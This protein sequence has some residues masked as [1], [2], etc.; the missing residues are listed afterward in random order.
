[1][2]AL[3][4]NLNEIISCKQNRLNEI[5]QQISTIEK[6]I[7]EI[8]SVS[9]DESIEVILQNALTVATTRQE[10]DTQ[11]EVL[12]KVESIA[13]QELEALQKQLHQVQI[14][15]YLED[16]RETASEC[17]KTLEFLKAQ[18]KKIRSLE[19]K[20]SCLPL[21]RRPITYNFRGNL[22]NFKIL[23]TCIVVEEKLLSSL[24]QINWN[25]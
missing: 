5:S 20:L 25:G 7:S 2:N 24:D 6:K 22:P 14:E 3:L 23:P 16:L 15:N 21:Q 12:I 8:S 18:F 4:V 9:S 17:N 13:R 10:L 1:M 11:K 19:A